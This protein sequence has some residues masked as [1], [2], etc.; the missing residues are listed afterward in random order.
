MAIEFFEKERIFLLQGKNSTYA[1]SVALDKTVGHHHWGGKIIDPIDIPDRRSLQVRR[2]EADDFQEYRAFGGDS[3]ITPALKVTFPDGARSA[4]L[5]YKSHS[6][7]VDTLTI[8]MTDKIYP[9]TVKLM[10]RVCEDFDV[11]ERWCE[12]RNDGDGDLTLESTY[13]ANWHFP[14][15][16]KYRITYLAGAYNREFQKY[17]EL[18][19]P[20]RRVL[21]SRTGLS[22]TD[23]TPV[24]F[25]Q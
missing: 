15:R 6:I 2:T 19:T 18:L 8:C 12:I 1:L 3:K 23:S 17:Q 11:I 5:Q 4:F 9:L 25:C 14:F 16:D 10:Y 13:S 21:E 22:G 24:W 7:D 20:G